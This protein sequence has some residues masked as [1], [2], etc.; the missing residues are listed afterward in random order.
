MHDRSYLVKALSTDLEHVIGNSASQERSPS[1]PLKTSNSE[2]LAELGTW[3]KSF[4]KPSSLSKSKRHRYA[5]Q[6][7]CLS[8]GKRMIMRTDEQ[9]KHVDGLES[10]SGL[11]PLARDGRFF[12]GILRNLKERPEGEGVK[13]LI[14]VS[15][16]NEKPD[17][18]INTLSGIIDNLAY[19]RQH[20]ISPK[21]IC[22]VVICDG[23]D[24]FMA[25]VNESRRSKHFFKQFFNLQAVY[26]KFNVKNTKELGNLI[27]SELK[28]EDNPDPEFAHCFQL[29][30][31]KEEDSAE[32][33]QLIWAVKHFNKRKLNTHL[34]FFGGFCEL[35]QPKYCQ[36]IDVGTRPKPDAIW[37]LYERLELDPKIAG[38]CGEIVP[39]NAKYWNFIEAAQIVEYKY[40][41][42]F[43]KA[44]E[45][46]VGYI[47]VLP[48]AFSAYRWK[49]LQGNPLWKDYFKSICH[50]E[51]MDAFN[52]NI[53]LAEDRVLC[54]A[55][56]TKAN[57]AYL[58]TYVQN[59]VA[60]TDIP[61]DIFKLLSQRRRWINGSWFALIDNLKRWKKIRKSNHTPFRQMAFTFLIFYYT[62]NVVFSW[63][64][65]GGFYLAIA[66]GFRRL[67]M[68]L[69][70]EALGKFATTTYTILLAVTFFLA[71]GVRPNQVEHAYKFLCW[72]FAVYIAIVILT[73]LYFV[74]VSAANLEWAPFLMLITVFC[75][76]FT[77]LVYKEFGTVMTNIV[78]FVLMTPT[79]VNIFMV[80]AICN[81]HDCTWGNRPDKLKDE[82]RQ[83][84]E[85]FKAF[86]TRWLALWA[87]SN[88]VYAFFFN[89][90]DLKRGNS[91]H[92]F[93]LTV[94]YYI[95]AVAVYALFILMVRF[96]GSM[97]FYYKYVR[98][99]VTLP[100]MPCSDLVPIDKSRSV[101]VPNRPEDLKVDK[102][103]ESASPLVEADSPESKFV[104]S[105]ASDSDDILMDESPEQFM[106]LDGL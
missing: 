66:I 85:E 81:T 69:G 77:P 46:L 26:E 38:C 80:Y 87:F 30:A 9:A 83:K 47:T 76:T 91:E 59:S 60:E 98:R 95:Y 18:V 5:T 88:A 21:D 37:R 15:M 75:F 54:L 24:F 92:L 67:T 52:S 45:S 104:L 36:L 57:E 27:E 105:E 65:V 8:L 48:G 43:D 10:C 28:S 40:A 82:E 102:E 39:M 62:L 56:V 101:Y 12:P 25:A 58:L 32:A 68:E 89:T 41:H 78:Q 93:G 90:L 72:S 2:K 34:W 63:L 74:G 42:L 22:C 44:L 55:L 35:L 51:I 94:E 70:V 97:L 53:Y 106:E 3:A 103:P 20:G 99:P 23:L 13:L 4:E 50:P 1:E 7:Q 73:L 71:L 61:S 19:F 29:T 100:E 33:L 16:F 14:A 49:A 17:E 6:Y 79:Y 96:I 11:F 86:R 31:T 84:E 64:M